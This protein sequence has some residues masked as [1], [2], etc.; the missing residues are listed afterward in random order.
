MKVQIEKLLSVQKHDMQIKSYE[1]QQRTLPK[2]LELLKHEFQDAGKAV[3]DAKEFIKKLQVERKNKELEVDSFDEKRKKLEAQLMSI[4]TNQEYKSI[5]KEIYGIKMDV[6]KIENE[7]LEVMEHIEEEDGQLKEKEA[8]YKEEENKLK[9]QEKLIQEEIKESENQLKSIRGDREA[10][11]KDIEPVVLKKY[12]KIL[13]RVKGEAIVPIRNRNCKGC[14][15]TL[16]PQV[17]VDVRRGAQITTCENC[18]RILIYA[19]AEETAPSTP[20]TENTTS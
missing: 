17:V 16:P 13:T 8:S 14:F 5:E 2:K 3:H 12:E 11:I 20:N 15:T 4:K 1:H 18:G 6:Q 7:I 9:E 10:L 19:E